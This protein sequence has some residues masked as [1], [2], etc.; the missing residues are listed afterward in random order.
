MAEKQLQN[1]DKMQ[2]IIQLLSTQKAKL[3]R[4]E[5][6]DLHVHEQAQIFAELDQTLR[7]RLYRY[8]TAVEVGDMFDAIE[9]E[10]EEVVKY[11]QEMPISYAAKV[12]D[13][14]YTDN[15]VDI[16]AYAQNKDLTHYLLALPEE[17]SAEIRS[18][19]HYE[20][21]TAGALM[22]TEYVDIFASQDISSAIK[23]IREEAADAELIYYAYVVTDDNELIGV[24]TLRDLLTN[25]EETL[26]SEIMTDPVI[27]VPVDEDQAEVARKVRDYNFVALPVIDY[28]N[29]LVGIINV[30]DV[31][32]VIDEENAGEY[33]GLAGVDTEETPEDP[34]RASL[35]RLP[36]L[37]I[38]LFLGM[39]TTT[40]IDHYEGLIS[41]ASILAVFVSLITG[42]AG[43]A[44]TQ[45]LAV[46]IRGLSDS[47]EE[48]RSGWKT[49]IS[50]LSTGLLTG[51]VTGLTICV[52]VGLWKN[53]W[54]LGSV[55]GV[56]LATAIIVATVAGSIIPLVMDKIGVDPAVASG[57]FISTLSDLTS[58]L[59]Y[60]NIAHQFLNFFINA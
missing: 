52:L 1:S 57:P 13:E 18:L 38:L 22:T 34:F 41:Q 20:D 27:S 58:V 5:Y 36:W 14:M 56:S 60:F 59:I 37:V 6:L 3:F 46:A 23:D 2:R 4:R 7:S 29:K 35:K 53:N 32:D 26:I 44:G 55:I 19:L 40:L 30:D 33:S 31:I 10:P 8:L 21:K 25:P 12:I 39:S 28:A 24:V 9:E 42:T 51:I 15:A 45:S 54:I 47:E 43:N 50:E 16:L 11:F 48:R 49:I 17:R